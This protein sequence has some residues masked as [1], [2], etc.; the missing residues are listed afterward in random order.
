M[1]EITP[2][3]FSKAALVAF[4]LGASSIV[5][6]LVTAL[7]ALYLG[8][9]AIRAINT[10]DGRLRGRP[11]AIAGLA[12]SAFVTVATAVGCVALVL[13]YVQERSRAVG[14]ANNLRLIGEAIH[15]YSD[16]HEHD[17]PPGTVV[18]PALEPSRRLSWEA[19]ILPHFSEGRPA[20]KRWEKLAKEIASDQAWDAPAHA[21]LR[22]N[23]AAYL[24]PS[25]AHELT[26]GQVGLTSYVGIAGVGKDAATL[27]LTDANAGFFGYDRLLRASDISASLGA[28]MAAL[29][30]GQDNGPWL[31]GGP[32]TV[33]GVAADSDRYIGVGAAFGGLHLYLNSR[34][35]VLWADGSV[36]AL[37]E[38]INPDLF[39]QQA[40]ITR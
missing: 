28:T 7:P 5:L 6:S 4:V 12:L 32:P 13:I 14:C 9:Q 19:A 36:R 27:P 18:N 22:R 39:R 23:I 20:G 15:S 34:A 17:F 2:S 25:F 38:Q 8:V 16:S 11:L 24:C 30:T 26:P 33:R 10:S 40:R 37:S 31:A 35:N 21:P 3:R 29:E 1:S